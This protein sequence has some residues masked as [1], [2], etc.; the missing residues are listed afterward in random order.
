MSLKPS[1]SNPIHLKVSY[2]GYQIFSHEVIKFATKKIY[3]FQL[4]TLTTL[5]PKS[6]IY[7]PIHYVEA[8]ESPFLPMPCPFLWSVTYDDVLLKYSEEENEMMHEYSD[9][10]MACG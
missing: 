1:H 10:Q 4:P 6:Y 5:R 3:M 8:R 7:E 9:W 2:N